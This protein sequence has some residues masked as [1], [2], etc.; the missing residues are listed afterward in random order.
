M[1]Y[2]YKG[3]VYYRTLCDI[4]PGTELLVFYGE[5]YARELGIE[6][7]KKPLTVY[8]MHSNPGRAI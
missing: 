6:E 5:S 8:Q 3:A 7:I 1:G 2:Q 4:Q